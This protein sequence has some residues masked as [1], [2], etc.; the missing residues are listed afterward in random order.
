MSAALWLLQNTVGLIP[1]PAVPDW[2]S[3]VSPI[4]K[5][6]QGAE[7]LGA[8]FPVQLVTLVVLAVAGINLVGFGIKLIRMVI[9][10]FTGG[11]GSS[12]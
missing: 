1:L 4:A 2:L 6:F 5:V 11:G 9:S 3:N 12:T 8:W 7:H 10:L